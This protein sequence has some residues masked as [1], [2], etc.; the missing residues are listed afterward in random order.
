MEREFLGYRTDKP[1]GSPVGMW[2]E[3][4]AFVFFSGQ[5]ARMLT[6]EAEA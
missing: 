6:K 1:D 2:G 5:G 4:C 3:D